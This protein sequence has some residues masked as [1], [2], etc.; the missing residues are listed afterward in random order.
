MQA[1]TELMKVQRTYKS[2]GLVVVGIAI[3]E[4]GKPE[5]NASMIRWQHRPKGR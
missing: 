2:Q 1:M 4:Q 3:N 5:E